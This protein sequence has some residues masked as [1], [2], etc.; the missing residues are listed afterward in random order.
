[1]L[2]R[3]A[4]RHC[5][6]AA[7]QWSSSSISSNS[8]SNSSRSSSLGCRQSVGCPQPGADRHVVDHQCLGS[9]ECAGLSANRAATAAGV[10]VYA[11][12]Q[13][14]QLKGACLVEMGTAQAAQLRAQQWKTAGRE[15][16]GFSIWS[17]KTALGAMR[18]RAFKVIEK[19]L[20]GELYVHECLECCA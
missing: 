2:W 18:S 1:M 8:S 9:R 5:M 17:E 19:G 12:T 4:S 10:R 11:V 7:R 6:R 3:H 14:K 16:Q 13:H 15:G 20:E